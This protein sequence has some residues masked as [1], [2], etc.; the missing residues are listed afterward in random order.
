[1]AVSAAEEKKICRQ[2]E[3]EEEKY[4]ENHKSFMFKILLPR[5]VFVLMTIFF[6]HNR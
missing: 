5:I 3:E 2:K 1:L 6:R 4:E